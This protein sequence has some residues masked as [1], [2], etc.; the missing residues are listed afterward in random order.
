MPSLLSLRAPWLWLA[1]GVTSAPD[2]LQWWWAIGLIVA[3]WFVPKMRRSPAG[4]EVGEVESAEPL[5]PLAAG[6]R[7]W[8]RGDGRASV[9][10]WLLSRRPG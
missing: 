2:G 10:R 8:E 4:A 5:H 7:P 6:S 1:I 9:L 3:S